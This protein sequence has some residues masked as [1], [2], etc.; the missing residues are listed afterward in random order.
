MSEENKGLDWRPL[1][2]K[3]MGRFAQS[4][5]IHYRTIFM[6]SDVAANPSRYAKE[7]N[8]WL[9]LSRSSKKAQ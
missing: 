6:G 7:D 1:L 9:N 4:S 5:G 8:N 2:V 3:L